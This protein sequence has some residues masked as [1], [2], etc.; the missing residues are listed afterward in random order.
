MAA[1]PHPSSATEPFGAVWLALVVVI[2]AGQPVSVAI[3]E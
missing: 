2:V 3:A 1:W